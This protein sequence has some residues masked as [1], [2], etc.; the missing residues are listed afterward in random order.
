MSKNIIIQH[1]TGELGPLEIASRDNMMAYAAMV[2]AEYELLRGDV[3][4]PGLRPMVQKMVMLGEQF[5]DYDDVL[6]VDIDQLAVV[7]LEENIF[8]IPGIGMHNN[9]QKG[10]KQSYVSTR[11]NRFSSP[12]PYWG[13]AI[14]K[15]SKDVRVMFREAITDDLLKESHES[16]RFNDEYLMS[17]LANI[18]EYAPD[19]CY[20]DSEWC[21][22][23]H[24]DNLEKAKMIHIRPKILQNGRQVR[25]KK[26]DVYNILHERGIL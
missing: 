21:Y 20:F 9:V 3:F 18:L 13:G 11:P 5:D 1:W 16:N 26:I 25:M 23:S 19:D 10:L 15:L 8:D 4:K 17:R 12:Y 22:C 24:K 6:M 7:G 14:W 2:G